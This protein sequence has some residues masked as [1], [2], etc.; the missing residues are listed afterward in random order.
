MT[1]IIIVLVEELI[2]Y[3]KTYGEKWTW[4]KSWMNTGSTTSPKGTSI[5]PRDGHKWN[6]LFVPTV[7]VNGTWVAI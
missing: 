1:K 4:F 3:S 2:G 5:A 7:P 6:A